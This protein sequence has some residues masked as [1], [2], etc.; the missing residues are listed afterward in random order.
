LV[1][2][3]DNFDSF[4]Y[5]LARYF[6]EIGSEVR[7]YRNNALTL[8]TIEIINPSHI[9]I[10]PGPCTPFEAG[11]TLDIIKHFHRRIP[12]LGVCLGHQAIG[13]SFG[14]KLIR[15]SR[16]MHGKTSLV[17]HDGRSLYHSLPSPL[18][19]A[20]Y[21]SLILKRESIKVVD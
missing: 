18:T 7:V 13:V 11:I 8:Q 6:C 3:I 19:A 12:I 21:H 1:L 2:L 16:L 15:A 10:S 5:N 20:R 17:F 4:T 14:A 9:V